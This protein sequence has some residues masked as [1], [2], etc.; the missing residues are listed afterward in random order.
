MIIIE[1]SILC[2]VIRV[3]TWNKLHSNVRESVRRCLAIAVAVCEWKRMEPN[4]HVAT[5]FLANNEMPEN[6]LQ[7]NWCLGR[8]LCLSEH[9]WPASQQHMSE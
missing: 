2:I 1:N 9:G 3:R 6:E 5:Y 7:F 4:L 8:N